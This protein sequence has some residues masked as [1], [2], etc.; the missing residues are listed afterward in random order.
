MFRDIPA[1]VS[2]PPTTTVAGVASIVNVKIQ[3]LFMR[4]LQNVYKMTL[5]GRRL[6]LFGSSPEST[7]P[8][9]ITFN[10]H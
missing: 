7:Q 8:N 1:K 5:R 10:L 6:R 3:D 9:P 4:H 2:L